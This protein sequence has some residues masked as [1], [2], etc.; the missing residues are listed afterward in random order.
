MISLTE[1]QDELLRYLQAR[2]GQGR[3]APSMR[4]IQVHMGMKSVAQAHYLLGALE[5]RGY[6]RRH[7]KMARAIELL[8][9]R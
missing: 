4:E 2:M 5:K 6:I 1:K 9:K 7:P 8:V 3:V